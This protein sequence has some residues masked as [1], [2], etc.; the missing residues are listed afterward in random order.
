[1]SPAAGCSGWSGWVALVAFVSFPPGSPDSC[2]VVW[3]PEVSW[4][5][6]GIGVVG[7]GAPPPRGRS[8]EVGGR[9]GAIVCDPCRRHPRV[10]NAG[11]REQ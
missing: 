5:P 11:H 7:G 4:P 1:V 6:E 9:V 3:L 8:M 2:V 10:R